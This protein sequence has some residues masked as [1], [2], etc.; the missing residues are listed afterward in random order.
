MEHGLFILL[1]GSFWILLRDPRAFN[2]DVKG[3]IRIYSPEHPVKNEHG[4]AI[5]GS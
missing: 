4:P 3:I 1:F 5:W 2:M